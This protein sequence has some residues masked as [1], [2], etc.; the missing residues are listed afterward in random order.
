[1]DAW[2]TNVSDAVKKPEESKYPWDYYKL[3]ATIRRTRR[4]SLV[5]IDL[6]DDQEVTFGLVARLVRPAQAASENSGA[7]VA[8]A[9][10]SMTA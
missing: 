10:S 6:P 4:F 9:H 5:E 7:G 8:A 1:M 3:K 2:F